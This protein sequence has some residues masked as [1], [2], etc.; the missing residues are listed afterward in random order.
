MEVIS[1]KEKDLIFKYDLNYV[2]QMFQGLEYLF[3]SLSIEAHY[4]LPE[5]VYPVSL[6][7]MY[8]SIEIPLNINVVIK[9]KSSNWLSKKLEKTIS[10]TKKKIIINY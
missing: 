7:V 5:N 9:E 10:K 8:N 1:S 4:K 2:K 6:S 3:I